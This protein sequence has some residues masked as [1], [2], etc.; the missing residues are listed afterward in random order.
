[1]PNK[2]DTTTRSR[3][4]NNSNPSVYSNKHIR[5]SLKLQEKVVKK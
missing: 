2:R 4:K 3:K 1:M 5:I